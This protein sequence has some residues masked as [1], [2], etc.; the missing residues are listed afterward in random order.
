MK[1]AEIGL[2]LDAGRS[3]LKSLVTFC[4]AAALVIGSGVM[5]FAQ[6]PVNEID[7]PSRPLPAVKSFD[8]TGPPSLKSLP[9]NLFQDQKNFWTSPLRMSTGSALGTAAFGVVIGGL[10]AAG[11]DTSIEKH[12]PTNDLLLA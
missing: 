6:A 2:A 11:G 4:R 10:A 1:I 9:R 3:P 12:L 7:L 5:A 8:L